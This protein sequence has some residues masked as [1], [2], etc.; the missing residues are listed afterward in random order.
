MNFNCFL[1]KKKISLL[2]LIFELVILPTF[3][4]N[5][6]CNC[7]VK[8]ESANHLKIMLN[9]N[10]VT[11][12]FEIPATYKPLLSVNEKAPTYLRVTKDSSAFWN[13]ESK[14]FD[15]VANRKTIKTRK[16]GTTFLVRL[17]FN[18]KD[19]IASMISLESKKSGITYI[20]PVDAL[21]KDF[22]FWFAGCTSDYVR[23]LLLKRNKMV[24][25]RKMDIIIENGT[26]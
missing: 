22:S 9:K 17:D 11:N 19:S 12:T 14:P 16:L 1:T 10:G 25:V 6:K 7:I 18:T 8:L 15:A 24:W 23:I 20:K 2:I 5:Y 21:D 4:Q 26:K 13:I 3:S